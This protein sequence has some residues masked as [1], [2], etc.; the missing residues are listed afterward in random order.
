MGAAA[1]KWPVLLGGVRRASPWF[2]W[3]SSTCIQMATRGCRRTN[4]QVTS[5]PTWCSSSLVSTSGTS[6]PFWFVVPSRRDVALREL[7]EDLESKI[8]VV[9]TLKTLLSVCPGVADHEVLRAPIINVFDGF[10]CWRPSP[11]ESAALRRVW[12]EFHVISWAT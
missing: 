10:S 7:W 11:P 4:S 1:C 2:L 3:V 8:D 12:S 6:R 9:R 5:S